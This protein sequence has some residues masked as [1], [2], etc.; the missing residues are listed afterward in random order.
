[1]ADG[2]RESL[3]SAVQLL[4]ITPVPAVGV[5]PVRRRAADQRRWEVD[6]T[7][8]GGECDQTRTYIQVWNCQRINWKKR[9]GKEK[10]KEEKEEEEKKHFSKPNQNWNKWL[11]WSQ[12]DGQQ[13]TLHGETCTACLTVTTIQYFPAE[14]IILLLYADKESDR[15]LRELEQHKNAVSG[16]GT[17]TCGPEF[18]DTGSRG[19]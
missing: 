9:K 3:S 13:K 4:V 8:W 1:M 6:K 2:M 10:G 16:L 18:A 11:S 17:H 14:N 15:K 12:R 7:G 5:S 19:V